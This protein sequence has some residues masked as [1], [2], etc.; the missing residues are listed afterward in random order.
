MLKVSKQSKVLSESL[1]AV[2]FIRQ[3]NVK[4][5]HRRGR[6]SRVRVGGAGDRRHVRRCRICSAEQYSFHNIMFLE[7]GVVDIHRHYY[8]DSHFYRRT[9]QERSDDI[10]NGS[11]CKGGSG[12]T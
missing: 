12:N 2:Q 6:M 4:D 5:I 10:Q 9:L 8:Q 7:S 3:F 1:T 11:P